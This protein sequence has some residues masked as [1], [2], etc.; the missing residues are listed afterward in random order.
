MTKLPSN[1]QLTGNTKSRGVRKEISQK[2]NKQ[3]PDY[4][5]LD[6]A[7]DPTSSANKLQKEIQRQ[8]Q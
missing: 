7:N 4:E 8:R 6:R 2:C 1:D 5:K 3:D